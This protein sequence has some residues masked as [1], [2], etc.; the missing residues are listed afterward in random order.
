MT[1]QNPDELVVLFG[2][3]LLE[4]WKIWVLI[5]Q[6][7]STLLLLMTCIV[8]AWHLGFKSGVKAA[9]RKGAD[10]PCRTHTE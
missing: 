6:L 9:N 1:L 10:L 4:K 8:I 5:A 7:A 3:V 2:E